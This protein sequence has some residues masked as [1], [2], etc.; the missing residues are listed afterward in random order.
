MF[1]HAED[2]DGCVFGDRCASVVAIA[3][4]VSRHVA[5]LLLPLFF[6]AKRHTQILLD[7]FTP[8]T[9]YVPLSLSLP[10]PL[11]FFLSNF[12]SLAVPLSFSLPLFLFPSCVRRV[13]GRCSSGRGFFGTG[14]NFKQKTQQRN[15]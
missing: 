15:E 13:G 11:S 9:I 1:L 12:L 5:F 14:A 10:I 3:R 8:L 4:L 6:L 2:E 7:F